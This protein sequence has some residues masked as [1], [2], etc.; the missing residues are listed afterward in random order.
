M[1][2][3]VK[4][5]LLLLAFMLPASAI[6][7]DFEVDGIYYKINGNEATVTYRG[8][9][10][11]Y[12]YSG[13][14]IIPASVTYNGTTYSVTTIGNA[15]FYECS[16]LTSVTIPNSVTTIE[17]LAFY[18]CSGLTSVTIPNSVTYIGGEAFAQCSGLTSVIV[19]SGNPKYDSRNNCNAIIETATNKLIAGCMSTIILNSVTAIGGNAF[20]GCSG[21]TSVTIPNSVTTIDGWAFSGCSSLTSINIPNSVTAIGYGAFSSCSGLTSV[22]VE[23][24]NPKYDSRNNCNA[25]I[26]TVTNTL[27]VGCMKTTIPNSVTHIGDCAFYECNGLA[28]ISIPNSVTSIGWGA[29]AQCSGLTSV[30]IGNSVTTIGEYAFFGCSGLTSVTIPNSVTTI[31]RSAFIG[32]SGL[33]SIT[34]G[35]SVTT[36]GDGAFWDCT[37]LTSITCLATTPPTLAYSEV[38]ES[39]TYSNATLKVPQ[40]SISAYQ[41]ADYWKNFTNIQGIADVFK[42]DGIYYHTQNYST[43]MV[44][45]NPE[46]EGYYQGDV[47]IPD[48]ITNQDLQFRVTGIENGAFDGCDELNSV[49]IGDAV[50]TIGEEAFQGCTGLTSVTIGNGVTSIGQRAFNYCNALQTVTCQ[51]TV[52]PVMANSNCFSSA[53]YRKAT[54]KVH[55]NYIDTYTATNY[56][57]KFENIEGFGSVGLGDANCDGEINIADVTT[58]IDQLLGKNSGSEFYF[59]SADLNGN[60][61]LDIGDVTTLIDLLLWSH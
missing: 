18:G 12:E 10:Y 32:C 33:T 21:L 57:Y 51:G 26:E 3:L 11:T 29:F 30:T 13:N 53:A 25:I 44:I 24:G 59:E 58:L 35:N 1:K 38:F 14:V 60:G 6:A 49:V 46:G 8:N 19:E 55:R 22:I 50:E 48:S 36:I 54:L 34:I 42:V 47:V 28:S 15:A 37:E 2:Q 17:G 56:W 43:A 27:I 5:S 20:N 61:H 45:P 41:A 16:G 39:S 31:E 4:L 40:S 23:S 9:S 52:P 7:H